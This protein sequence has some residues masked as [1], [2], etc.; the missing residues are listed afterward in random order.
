LPRGIAVIWEEEFLAAR[1][2]ASGHFAV[3]AA[4]ASKKKPLIKA[5]KAK[6]KKSQIRRSKKS[7]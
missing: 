5:S 4:R 3:H 1:A 7:S 2:L 6:S